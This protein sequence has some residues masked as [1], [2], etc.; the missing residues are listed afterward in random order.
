VGG[1]KWPQGL[2]ELVNRPDRVH[3]YFVNWEDVFFF[4]GDTQTL[5]EFL[6]GYAKLE[7]TVLELVVHPG[8]KRVRSPWDKADRAIHADWSLYMSPIAREQ[9]EAGKPTEKF[10]TR[11][12]VYLGGKVAL[13]GLVVPVNIETRSGGELEQFVAAHKGKQVDVRYNP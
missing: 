9:I 6:A 13:D 1:D 4:S 8:P 2:N 11:V 5:N 3:G 10:V 12:D 7:T